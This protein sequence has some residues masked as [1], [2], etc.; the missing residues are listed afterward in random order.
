MENNMG[1]PDLINQLNDITLR[2]SQSI[3]KLAQYGKERAESEYNY[4]IKVRQEAFKM[5]T[6]GETATM[7]NLAVRGEKEVAKAMLERD[8]AEAMYETAQENINVLKLQARLLESQIDREW[9]S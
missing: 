1:N 5:K 7:I 3:K 4:R 6:E 9:H 8:I 2:M